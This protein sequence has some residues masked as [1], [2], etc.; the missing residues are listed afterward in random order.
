MILHMTTVLV[1]QHENCFLRSFILK[2]LSLSILELN[3]GRCE[4]EVFSSATGWGFTDNKTSMKRRS[5]WEK[6][7]L[8]LADVIVCLRRD[9]LC[10]IS[11]LE[12]SSD[13]SPSWWILFR[14]RWQQAERDNEKNLIHMD[15]KMLAV[16]VGI[17]LHDMMQWC[18]TDVAPAT[19][20]QTQIFICLFGENAAEIHLS[21]R[22]VFL[23]LGWFIVEET[24]KL[25]SYQQKLFCRAALTFHCLHFSSLSS[26]VI[27]HFV[28]KMSILVFPES[29]EMSLN[30]SF[31]LFDQ[32]S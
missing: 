25:C 24:T 1:A 32:Q 12:R 28:Y 9:S 15:R 2:H 20:K 8:S 4:K 14:R 5:E 19:G 13:S 30:V 27:N 6:S 16:Y 11:S 23:S 29:K 26:K 18:N 7:Q 10:N 31:C 3:P 17:I 21:C 22:I